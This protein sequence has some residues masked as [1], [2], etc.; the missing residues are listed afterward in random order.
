[1]KKVIILIT[2][3]IFTS[4]SFAETAPICSSTPSELT[5]YF[6]IILNILSKV[7]QTNPENDW[8]L[9]WLL[10]KTLENGF[11]WPAILLFFWVE[12][13]ANFFQNIFVIFHESYI[14]RDWVKLINFKQYLTK[15][16][17]QIWENGWLYEDLPSDL[18]ED[19]QKQIN[20]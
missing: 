11:W 2:L 8:W 1:M 14:V 18:K 16:F 10:Q 4:F 9:K 5:N 6:S 17:L 20:T 15:K 3:I 13:F 7:K 12:W 19:L